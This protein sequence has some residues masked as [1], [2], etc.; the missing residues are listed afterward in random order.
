[1]NCAR[2]Y[3]QPARILCAPLVMK[4]KLFLFSAVVTLTVACLTGCGGDPLDY[5]T[6]MD[7]L[8]ERTTD[9]VRTSFSAAPHFENRDPGVLQAYQRPMDE[10]VIQCIRT[11][12]WE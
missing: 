12:T 3:S 5:A 4:F 11:R 6:A 8:R 2:I 7:L 10:H 1:M 9:P